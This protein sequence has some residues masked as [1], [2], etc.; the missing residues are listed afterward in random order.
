MALGGVPTCAR[1]GNLHVFNV[2]PS[3]LQFVLMA[4][5]LVFG[6]VH[7][8]IYLSTYLSASNLHFNLS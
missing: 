3:A 7:Q 4:F 8:A 5:Q 1:V 2:S 6:F